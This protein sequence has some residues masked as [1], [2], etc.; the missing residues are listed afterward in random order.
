[1]VV[2]PKPLLSSSLKELPTE[3]PPT[4][5]LKSPKNNTFNLTNKCK[6]T[7]LNLTDLVKFHTTEDFKNHALPLPRFHAIK[8]NVQD[9]AYQ[10]GF[11]IK[12]AYKHPHQIPGR[13]GNAV[14][15]AASGAANMGA[16]LSHA[17]AAEAGGA[18]MMLVDS[19]GR[20]AQEAGTSAHRVA[21]RAARRANNHL[22]GLQ[23]QDGGMSGGY[24]TEYENIKRREAEEDE[25]A[26]D[27]PEEEE[28]PKYKG[29]R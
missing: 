9:V 3:L 7:L 17:V 1:M 8:C 23:E 13:L 25:D 4:E 22:H 21:K 19:C 28:K 2:P 16:G 20:L 29:F 18:G 15:G 5:L 14:M 24:G 27:W 26:C 12:N 10:A 11:E 6:N